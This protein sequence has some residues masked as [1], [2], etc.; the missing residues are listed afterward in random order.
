MSI[1]IMH[2]C[3][4]WHVLTTYLDIYLV[5][6][7]ITYMITLHQ[8]FTRACSAIE[9]RLEHRVDLL[10]GDRFLGNEHIQLLAVCSYISN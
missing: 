9:S 10:K 6:R 7:I 8:V 4:L 5:W 3:I 1:T 2:N